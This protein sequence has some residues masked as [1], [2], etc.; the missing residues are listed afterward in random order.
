LDERYF[1]SRTSGFWV[2]RCP[3]FRNSLESYFGSCF[4]RLGVLLDPFFSERL[5][6]PEDQ[7]EN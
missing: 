7:S 6:N 3:G 5:V 2:L 1:L 4:S